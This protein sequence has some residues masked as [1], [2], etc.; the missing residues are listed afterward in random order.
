MQFTPEFLNQNKDKLY[1]AQKKVTDALLS[2]L[3]NA[4]DNIIVIF[5]DGKYYN[6]LDDGIDFN[7]AFEEESKLI[8][9]EKIENYGVDITKL[10]FVKHP[11]FDNKSILRIEDEYSDEHD[12]CFSKYIKAGVREG[13]DEIII[14]DTNILND[15][16]E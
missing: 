14:I 4:M 1:F 13:D 11:N 9:I 3:F 2:L 12:K 7:Q 16:V 6:I 8:R 15:R 5:I 10:S